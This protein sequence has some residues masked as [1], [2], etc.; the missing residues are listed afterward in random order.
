MKRNPTKVSIRKASA[1]R[2][3]EWVVVWQTGI[4]PAPA[5][6]YY[7]TKAE[8]KAAAKKIRGNPKP[9]PAGWIKAKAVKVIRNKRGQAVKLRIQT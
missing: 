5:F 2:K 6:W 3:G 4:M 8:A 1:P 9:N 7:K